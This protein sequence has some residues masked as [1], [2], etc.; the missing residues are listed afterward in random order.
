M[1]LRQEAKV[2][3]ITHLI[4]K[5]AVEV[6]I[7]VLRSVGRPV[8]KRVMLLGAELECNRTIAVRS[9]CLVLVPALVP[10]HAPACSYSRNGLR[11][12]GVSCFPLS[13][14][15]RAAQGGSP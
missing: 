9:I 1:L 6:R 11:S 2:T 8:F 12:V 7:H 14:N 15:R 13:Y 5:P 3:S 4:K 10:S